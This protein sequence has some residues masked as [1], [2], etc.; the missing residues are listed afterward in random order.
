MSSDKGITW[1]DVVDTALDWW[2]QRQ[3]RAAYVLNRDIIQVTDAKRF[4]YT[5]VPPALSAAFTP[6]QNGARSGR[7]YDFGVAGGYLNDV[8]PLGAKILA[9]P[10]TES[11]YFARLWSYAST[12]IDA[13]NA[14]PFS[15]TD[16]SGA[17]NGTGP[18]FIQ[19]TQNAG[20]SATLSYLS[21]RNGGG[22]P[23]NIALP[24][25]CALGGDLCPF[26]APITTAVYFDLRAGQLVVEFQDT[27]VLRVSA[28]G[29]NLVNMPT[30]ALLF[31]AYENNVN[32]AMRSYGGFG[33][34]KGPTT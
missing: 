26:A 18:N 11:W 27:E 21:L 31:E 5:T 34:L 13:N 25:S 3:R 14:I 2:T 10:Q 8:S 22:G 4:D 33:M 17:A 9:S 24:A 15:L 32:F 6:T 7:T 29:G 20:L 12:T 23:Q 16:T 19:I 30:A 28:A 1:I